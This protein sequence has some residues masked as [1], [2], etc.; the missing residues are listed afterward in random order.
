MEYWRCHCPDRSV[1]GAELATSLLPVESR[2][3]FNEVR[4][5]MEISKVTPGS[6]RGQ[7]K[8]RRV[9]VGERLAP[10]R[11]Q[12]GATQGCWMGLQRPGVWLARYAAITTNPRGSLGGRAGRRLARPLAHGI[13]GWKCLCDEAK[14]W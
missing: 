3:L 7:V 8:V 2:V 14:L 12:V 4:L 9:P 5:S 13:I 6:H 1:G 11:L 10:Q